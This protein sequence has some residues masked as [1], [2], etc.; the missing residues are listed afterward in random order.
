M[1]K[2]SC[3]FKKRLWQW[4]GWR[5]GRGFDQFPVQ[6][7]IIDR[8]QVESAPGD[9]WGRLSSLHTCGRS[10]IRSVVQHRF[11]CRLGQK[12]R[13]SSTTLTALQH[14]KNNTNNQT[15]VVLWTWCCVYFLWFQLCKLAWGDFSCFSKSELKNN[16]FDGSRFTPQNS[17]VRTFRL[18]NLS[19]LHLHGCVHDGQGN[20]DVGIQKIL[21][22]GACGFFLLK[23]VQRWSARK[24]R[25]FV[26]PTGTDREDLKNDLLSVPSH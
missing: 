22:D 19:C 26:K 2:D 13:I 10:L 9:F 18:C 20:T 3:L 11:K 16:I 8:T 4:K 14:C 21:L 6:L 7:C 12:G 24:L 25:S 1:R 5:E 15:S 23:A 17:L